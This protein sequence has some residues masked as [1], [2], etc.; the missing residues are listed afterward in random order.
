MIRLEITIQHAP[1]AYVTA[2][3]IA[4]LIINKSISYSTIEEGMDELTRQKKLLRSVLK[5]SISELDKQ[6]FE[7]D[8]MGTFEPFKRGDEDGTKANKR[9]Q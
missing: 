5:E 1:G 7:E 9:N 2:D 6:I 3:S 4:K 8:Y